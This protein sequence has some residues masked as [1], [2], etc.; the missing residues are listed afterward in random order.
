MKLTKLTTL[1][2]VD[3]IEPCL[4][5]WQALGYTITVRVPEEGPLGFTILSGP[6]GELMLQTRA[7]LAEDMPAV[8]AKLPSHLLYGDVASLESA[9]KA[10]LAGGATVLVARRKTFYGAHEVWFELTNG[11]ILGL[12]EHAI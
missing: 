2:V 1:L 10:V 4:N 3:A 8:H 7:S 12:A 5:T 9:A 11:M 6:A